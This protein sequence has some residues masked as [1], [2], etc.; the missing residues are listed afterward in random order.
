MIVHRQPFS[1]CSLALLV[2]S[3]AGC[4]GGQSNL[5]TALRN[6]DSRPPVI[7]LSATPFFP[8]EDY[9]CGPAALATVLGVSG[10]N[11]T[12]AE[13]TPKVYL[14]ERKGSLQ[15]EL[16]AAT[17]RYARIPYPVAPSLAALLRE[18]QGGHPVLV[19]QNLGVSWLPRWH[20][21]VVIGYAEDRDQIILRSG[22]TARKEMATKLFMR[23]WRR[24]EYWGLVVLKPGELPVDTQ[25]EHYLEAVSNL[26]MSGAYRESLLAYQAALSRWPGNFWARFGVANSYLGLGHHNAAELHL[27][28]LLVD[29]PQHPAVLNNLAEVLARRGCLSKAVNAVRQG[30]SAP[31]LT[32][33]VRSVLEETQREITQLQALCERENKCECNR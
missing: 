8:Q 13:L 18:L 5:S 10:V 9:Q 1:L 3:L 27:R 30:L 7:E 26:E 24:A 14:P 16:S 31:H 2:V 25:P 12:P 23:T 17:R 29:Y 28:E 32:P 11:V 4:V 21:A 20:Y 33:P 19:L 15:L 6:N 22:T